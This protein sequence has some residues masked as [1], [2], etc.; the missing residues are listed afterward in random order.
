MKSM[1]LTISSKK[2]IARACEI[3]NAL[4]FD[5]LYEVI[6][7]PVENNRSLAQNSIYHMWI[8]DIRPSLGYTHEELHIEFKRKYLVPLLCRTDK[9]Y[10]TMIDA[11]KTLK[12]HP[13]FEAI[14][15]EVARLTSTTRLKIK[16]FT[17]YLES[18]EAFALDHKVTLRYPDLIHHQAMG[19]K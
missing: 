15:K 2:V 4:G 9:D 6:I 18:I 16:G 19:I 3:I 5:P 13:S 14:K 12:G 11:V 7:Q 17:E 8:E 10:K 1:T